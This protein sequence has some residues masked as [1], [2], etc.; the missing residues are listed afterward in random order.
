MISGKII[1]SN[2]R[3]DGHQ[4][5]DDPLE[6]GLERDSAHRALGHAVDHVDVDPHRRC[7]NP[8]LGHQDDDHAEPDRVVA[9]LGDHRKENGDRQHDQR[10]GVHDAPA[11]K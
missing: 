9:E 7:D 10:Q 8:H 5:R 4:K 2:P 11:Q 3:D 1:I 6:D